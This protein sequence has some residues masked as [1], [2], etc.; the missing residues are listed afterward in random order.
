M[1]VTKIYRI[2]KF[3]Q[4]EWSKNTLILIQTKEKIQLIVMKFFFLKLMNNRVFGKTMENLRKRISV[5]L[6]NIAKDYVRCISKTRFISQKIFSKN[7]VAT[8]EVKPV[9]TLNK[10]VYI[11]F[12]ILHLSKLLMHQFPYKDINSKSDAKL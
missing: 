9:L 12:S 7:F 8:H 4:S 3:K 2:V 10:P 1:K 11:G 5:R 6:I